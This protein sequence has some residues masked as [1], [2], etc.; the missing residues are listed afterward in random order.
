MLS[1]NI[2]FYTLQYYNKNFTCNLKQKVGQTQKIRNENYNDYLFKA[3]RNIFLVGNEFFLCCGKC[4]CRLLLHIQHKGFK[5]MHLLL[6]K[7]CY[8][9]M[10]DLFGTKI[11]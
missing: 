5:I 6:P 9:I 8:I 1:M 4:Y 2:I 3:H 11:L 7:T 10:Y